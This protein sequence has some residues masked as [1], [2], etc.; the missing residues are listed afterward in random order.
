ME[1]L[2]EMEKSGKDLQNWQ[3]DAKGIFPGLNFLWAQQADVPDK[4][5][6]IAAAV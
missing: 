5:I 3:N 1:L 4:P 2:E 6:H